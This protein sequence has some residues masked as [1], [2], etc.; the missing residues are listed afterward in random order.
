MKA[1]YASASIAL[2]VMSSGIVLARDHHH[3]SSDGTQP[4]SSLVLSASATVS[5]YPTASAPANSTSNSTTPGSPITAG[6]CSSCDGVCVTFGATSGDLWYWWNGGPG[7]DP[8][9]FSDKPIGP[10]CLTDAGAMFVG[11]TNIQE[12]GGGNTKFEWSVG[13][14]TS[15]FDVSVCDGFSVPMVCTGFDG[16]ETSTNTIG[17]GE[18]CAG[19]CPAGELKGDNCHNPG[20]HTGVL[21]EVPSCFT[22]G[23][24]PDGKESANNNYWYYD[25]VSVQAIFTDRTDIVCTVGAIGGSSSKAKRDVEQSAA[26][27]GPRASKRHSHGHQR[28][29][30]GHGLHAV[31]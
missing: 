24:A 3:S 17:G 30:H 19:D 21:A 28:R 1:T 18:L 6:T 27:L 16:N 26:E 29:A 4:T 8:S 15:N 5:A 20:A 10:V 2:A 14:T 31:S 13:A 22:E 9:K 11:A 23:A 25:N 7:G 12:N